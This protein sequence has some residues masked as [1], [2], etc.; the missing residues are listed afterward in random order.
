M[1]SRLIAFFL[2]LSLSACSLLPEEEDETRN[3][4][5]QK[6]YTEASSAMREGNYQ[7]AIKYYELLEARYPFGKYALQS[8]LDLAYAYYRDGEPESA[9]AA[10]DRFIRLNP[11]HPAVAYA[12]YL[13]GIVNFN[14][15][16]GFLTRFIPT[17]TSQ[18]DPGAALDS[19]KDFSE[20]TRRFPDSEYADDA[21]KR[22]IFLRNNLAKHELHVA[23]Y[24]MERSAYVAAARR[25]SAVVEKY[26]RTPS[27]KEALE[28]MIEAYTKLGKDK[29]AADTHRVFKLNE[30]KGNFIEDPI[31][32]EEPTIGRKVW[33]YFE[34]DKN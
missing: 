33:D 25:A 14:R 27:V 15:R 24:Y 3:W 22:M 29:L 2:V 8:Q 16:L 20:L 23:R 9:L 19:F 21:R 10:A 6:F 18:R 26:Q 1:I 4:S 17:D 11:S 30:D 5:A 12:L 28:I 7:T 32:L 31:D 13:K 34:L